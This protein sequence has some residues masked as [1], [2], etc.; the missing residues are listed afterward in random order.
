MKCGAAALAITKQMKLYMKNVNLTNSRNKKAGFY[1]RAYVSMILITV[2]AVL[3]PSANLFTVSAQTTV[4]P[5]GNNI[6]K[7]DFKIGFS[8]ATLKKNPKKVMDKE[9]ADSLLEVA[10]SLNEVIALP[11][12]V[13]LN[14]DKCGEPNA[15]YNPEVK[16]ITMCYE[17]LL[18]FEQ[19]L[20]RFQ[21]NRLKLTI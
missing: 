11:Y 2:L 1:K 10:K 20:K 8:P 9:V 13:Y 15:F 5:A 18:D 6:D 12:D 16:E 3:M 4:K 14:F 17:F 7:G 19:A 21:K